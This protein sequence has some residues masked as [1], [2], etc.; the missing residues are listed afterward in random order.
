MQDFIDKAIADIESFLNEEGISETALGVGAVNDANA[1]KR[2]R[3]HKV[4]VRTIERVQEYIASQRASRNQ[5][6]QGRQ[7]DMSP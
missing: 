6:L 4:T 2:I 3:Q 7:A 1:I 5:P